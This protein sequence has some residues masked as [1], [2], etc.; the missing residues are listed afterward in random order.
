MASI[1]L[2]TSGYHS[3]KMGMKILVLFLLYSL[4][5]MSFTLAE[6]ET[7][8]CYDTGNF[9]EDGAYGINRDTI[10]SSLASSTSENGGFY[11]T[12][13]GENANK[14]YVLAL[15]R[16]DYSMENCSKCVNSTSQD[17]IT[18]CP[19]QKEAISWDPCIVH[20]ANRP[21]FGVYELVPSISL[22]NEKVSDH[23]MTE[24][25]FGWLWVDL[26]IGISKKTEASKLKFAT[27]EKQV[28]SSQTIY[29]LM[30]CTPDISQDDCHYCLGQSLI[31]FQKCCLGKQG[32]YTMTPSCIFRWDFS[33]FYA[34]SLSSTTKEKSKLKWIP[35]AASSS[36]VFGL[37]VLGSVSFIIWRRRNNSNY[38]ENSQ[39]VQLLEF[40]GVNFGNNEEVHGQKVGGSEKFPALQFDI[41]N[42]ATERFCAA[43]KLGEG[44]FGPVY[45]GILV[46]GKE[47]AVKRLSGTSGQGLVEFKNEVTLIARLQHRNL[48][49]LLGCCLEGDEK[50]LV[51][52]YMP[53]RSLD[54]FL[55]GLIS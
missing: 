24:N 20:Y 47:I 45:K 3:L 53:N 6:T 21:F 50:L 29:A 8:L 7:Q 35:I 44:G 42:T 41:I 51:Y 5:L 11:T 18:K 46:D 13:V 39:E 43:N 23:N 25:D 54:V 30:Q 4:P 36:T 28:T 14:V 26:M 1:F 37:I 49:R 16:E 15:C 48:V 12:T 22:N 33:P 2:G 10:L 9:T 17:L 27:G 32:G 38:K 55:F 19:N 31:T 40:G 34:P 52:E